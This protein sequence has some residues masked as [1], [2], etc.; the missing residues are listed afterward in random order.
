MAVSLIR[1]SNDRLAHSIQHHPAKVSLLTLKQLFLIVF[2]C[3]QTALLILHILYPT[4]RTRA[5]LAAATLNV[6][7]AIG[8]CVLSHSEHLHSIRPSAVIN[9]YLLLTLPFDIVRSRTLFGGATKPVA[10]LF[11][12]ALVIKV[13]ILIAEAIDK[14]NILLDRYKCSSPEVTSG[15]YS[16]SFFWWLNT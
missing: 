4:L 10:A 15:I 3:M 5:T 16:R 9:V 8:L 6:L 7:D 1:V 11:T 2:A 14:Q 13:M 12:S